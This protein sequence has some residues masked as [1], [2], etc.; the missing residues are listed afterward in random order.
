[1]KR[2][3]TLLIVMTTCVLVWAQTPASHVPTPEDFVK[4]TQY[5][6]GAISPDG[7]QMLYVAWRT[8]YPASDKPV[9]H[10]YLVSTAG[11]ASRQMTAS[12]A[13]ESSP[14]WA[15]DGQ[16]FA[17]VSRRSG[18]PQIFVMPIDGGEGIQVG[19]LKIAPQS[20]LRWS[21]DGKSLAF[22]AVPEPT[23]AE[24]AEEKQN[25]G[26]E[27]MEAPHE[28]VQLFTLSV[29]DGKLAMVTPGDYNVAEFDWAPDGKSFALVTAETQLLYDN[30][31]STSV[32]VVDLAGKALAVLSPK[33]GP[34]QGAALFSPDG[35]RVAWRYATKGLSEMD[36]VAVASADG[37]SFSNAAA[38]VDYHF[39]QIAWMADGKSLMAETMEG[40]R[41][42][43]RRLDLATGQAPLIYAPAGVIWGFQMDRAGKRIV[44]AFTDPRSPRNPWSVDADGT[45]PTQ[46][47]DLNPQV[48]EWFLPAQE[49]IRYE[50]A[51]GVTI[52]A[53]YDKTPLPPKDG[54][55][56]LMVMPHGG[57]DWM[58][59]EGF[60][61]WVIYFAGQGYSVLR[62]NFRGSLGY[63]MAFYEAN[64]GKEGFAD[65]DDVMAGV[66]TLIARRMAD[67]K[68][69]VIGGWS[70]GGCFSEWAICRT[71]RFK[72]AVVGA[73]VADYISNYAQSDI[74]H[75]LA[76]EWEFLG[77]PYDAPE[78]YMKDSAVFHIRS[79]Q[80]P[81]LIL[82][83]KE[84]SRVPYAQGLELYRA[85]KTTGKS[86]EMVSYPG[87]NHGFRKPQHRIDVLKRWS[88]FYDKALG[89]VRPEE[90]KAERS[91]TEG[92]AKAGGTNG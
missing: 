18:S 37:K 65:Y 16:S 50:S 14:A 74:N 1:M 79:V 27:I 90:K 49:K 69:L 87:E 33:P 39:F 81:V 22:L 45:D 5:R 7:S 20:S 41:S 59:Q 35:S 80:T 77:N 11:G 31:T 28:M 10:I 58:D 43:L 66:D 32:R 73:G 68:K 78:N 21:P 13:G 34:I 19:A 55:A 42:C 85:L 51:R 86:V 63:G 54:V 52:E 17:F 46:L 29:P 44:F 60:D 4:M 6:G 15:P 89:I 24:K 36:G 47:A 61:P 88:A 30:M 92:G 25:G 91:G 48:K 75:G 83:G 9:G 40:T 12:E 53:L 57:P 70:Y 71:N 2:A 76:G 82:H 23:P 67:P 84:D 8:D 26:V 64:R 38:G 3:V 56:P 62:V 72:A